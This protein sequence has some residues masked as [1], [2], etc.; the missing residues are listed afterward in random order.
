M[1]KKMTDLFNEKL[2]MIRSRKFP[3]YTRIP[4]TWARVTALT[5]RRFIQNQCTIKAASLTFYTLFAIVPILALLFGLAK[6]LG[7]DQLLAEK[8]HAMTADYPEIA[9]QIIKFSET[10]LQNA[11]GGVVAGIGVLLLMWSAIKL[12]GSIEAAMNGIWG[13]KRGRTLI[14]K[15]TDYITILIICPILL[16]AA[17]SAM[18]FAATRVDKIVGQFPGGE[19][20][21][22]VIRH[23]HGLLPMAIIWIVFTFIYLVIPNTK[24]R[25]SA[26]ALSGLLTSIVYTLLQTFYIFL[27]F[28][29]AKFNAIYGSF[30]A[31]PLFLVWLNL[32]W[33]LI[34]AGAQLTFSI[35]N[36]SEYEMQPA[37]GG[38]SQFQRYIYSMEIVSLLIRSFKLHRGPVSDERLSEALELPIR[39]VRTLLFDLAD[40]KIL[41]GGGPDETSDERR[42]QIAI[43]PEEITAVSLIRALNALGG[44]R[45]ASKQDEQ[46]LQLFDRIRTQLDA[47]PANLPLANLCAQIPAGTDRTANS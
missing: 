38:M 32:S 5:A 11:K 24:V 29:T 1:P 40:A 47:P 7:W 8:L 31:L 18:A 27:Q 13:V 44:H 10:M 45:F 4:L 9:E 17:G 28:T 30:A 23:G 15:V 14:R 3:F 43:P 41:T 34:L 21:S 20:F 35:Q 46:Y 36:V 39:A 22:S 19:I 33:I 42:Y 37:D 6:G 26:A 12:L 16:L 2:W 25:F